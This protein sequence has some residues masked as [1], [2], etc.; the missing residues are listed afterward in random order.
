MM[1]VI[2]LICSP[3]LYDSSVEI[4]NRDHVVL[5]KVCQVSLVDLNNV[6]NITQLIS[7]VIHSLGLSSSG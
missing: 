2:Q 7:F 3:L 1:C 6:A 5:L 4:N